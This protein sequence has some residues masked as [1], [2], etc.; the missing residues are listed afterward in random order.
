M[1]W[2]HYDG[3]TDQPTK[4]PGPHQPTESPGPQNHTH[5]G[6]Q[7]LSVT[8]TRFK[9]GWQGAP[10]WWP[11]LSAELQSIADAVLGPRALPKGQKV[12]V[13]PLLFTQGRYLRELLKVRFGSARR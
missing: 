5:A 11:T 4:F 6:D 8:L 13:L 10:A 9:A 2:T 3:L 7:D 12:Q 1:D